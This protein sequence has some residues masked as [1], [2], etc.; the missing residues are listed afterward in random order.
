MWINV[1]LL[2][3]MSILEILYMLDNDITPKSDQEL[4]SIDFEPDDYV[5]IYGKL[6]Y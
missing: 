4:M 6:M 1:L 3:F 5:L 2:V